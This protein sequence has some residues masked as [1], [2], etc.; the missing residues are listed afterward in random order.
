R[1]PVGAEAALFAAG[2]A[3][4]FVA[5][6]PPLAT[7]DGELFWVH[8]T[9]H[10]LLL[11]VAPPLILL[12][13]PWS[14]I[15]RA[16][17]LAVRRPAARGVTR[18]RM[19]TSAPFALVVFSGTLVIWHVPL[20]YDATLRFSGVHVLEHALFLTTGLLFWSQLID[21]PPFRSRLDDPGRALYAAAGTAAGSA[22]GLVL[23][24][25]ST[26]LYADYAELRSRPGGISALA[27]QHLAAGIMLVPGSVPFLAACVVF[28]YR[29][30]DVSARE[31][32]RV[33]SPVA[34]ES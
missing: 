25:A 24:L 33:S 19:L 27:D 32:R 30:L 7:F 9:Q 26:P 12:G 20:L 10:V 14:T 23:A 1:R 6:A 3:A 13:R 5:F 11:A 15:G 34:G 16:L 31:G 29:W 22:L 18:A 8:M 4:L 17:P 2:L 21:T 28:L